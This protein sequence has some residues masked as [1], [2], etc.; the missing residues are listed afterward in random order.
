M[1]VSVLKQTHRVS[2]NNHLLLLL[3]RSHHHHHH[4]LVQRMLC[5]RFCVR[6]VS[7]AGSVTDHAN[8][9][10]SSFSLP[11]SSLA[12]EF[13]PLLHAPAL[14]TRRS[15]CPK[16]FLISCSSSRGPSR[17]RSSFGDHHNNHDD[18][19]EASL[20]ISGTLSHLFLPVLLRYARWVLK[21]KKKPKNWNF[22]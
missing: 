6:A 13:S 8:A 18:Y 5:Y 3:P 22:G 15:R 4:L 10:R 2:T 20:L 14:R 11:H 7:G 12:I 9:T 19:L 17:S 21:K 16:T 1:C